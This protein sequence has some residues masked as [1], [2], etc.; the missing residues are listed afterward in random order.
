[1][2]VW[3]QACVGDELPQR[4]IGPITP[5]DFARFSVSMDDPNR[6][7]IEDAVAKAAGLPSVIG[8]G[9]IVQGVMDDLVAAWAGRA[10]PR[11]IRNRILRPLL[12]DTAVRVVGRVVERTEDAGRVKVVVA[13]EA[14]DQDGQALGDASCTLAAESTSVES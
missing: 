13:I 5:M 8:S 14:V 10:Q 1:M 3:M 7:H 11:V 6:V 9:G 2:S 4:E 12:P